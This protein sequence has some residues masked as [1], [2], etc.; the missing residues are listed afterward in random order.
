MSDSNAD[1]AIEEL[2]ELAGDFAAHMGQRAIMLMAS[3]PAD[4]IADYNKA[5]AIIRQ[6]VKVTSELGKLLGEET[7]T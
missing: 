3:M 7:A 6:V 1:D 2:C 5:A 4:V